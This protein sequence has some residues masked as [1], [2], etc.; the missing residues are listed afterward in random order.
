MPTTYIIATIAIIILA[1]FIVSAVSY[2]KQQA[3]K[4]INHMVKRYHQQA[5]EALSFIS[6]LLR[7]DE[8]YDLIIQLQNLVVNALS[9]AFK[10]NSQ[11][12]MILNNL[13]TQKTKLN[14]YKDKQRS[15]ELCCWFTSNSELN[16]NLSQLAQL[17]KLLDLYRN[18]GDLSF[19]K[20]QDLQSHIHKLQQE[21]TINSNLYQADLCAE[22][23]NITS[24]QL[25]IKRAI[26][27][28]KKSTTDSIEKNKMIKVL[29]ERIKE[30]KRTG[31]TNNFKN[32]IKPTEDIAIEKDQETDQ[33]INI[34]E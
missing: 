10:F 27:V 8:E 14:K 20:H 22:Q 31:K 28:I 15:I 25:Y 17:N 29:S 30:V 7:I 1:S 26:Q 24:Y 16:T 9:N 12:Q 32:F 2:S 5:D 11:D 18:K 33:E 13:N 19:S 23:N 4:K 21:L 3:L 34:T 6:L